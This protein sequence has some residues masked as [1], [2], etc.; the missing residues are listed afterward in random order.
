MCFGAPLYVN[1]VPARLEGDGKAP[2]TPS[3][4]TASTP[5]PQAVLLYQVVLTLTHLNKLMMISSRMVMCGGRRSRGGRRTVIQGR[6]CGNV[7]FSVA[8]FLVFVTLF[9]PNI[10]VLPLRCVT[11]A[12]GGGGVK[13]GVGSFGFG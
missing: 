12:G 3:I 7:Y 11:T 2:A 4:I 10:V 6:R 13:R 9:P 8:L 5:L 1:P